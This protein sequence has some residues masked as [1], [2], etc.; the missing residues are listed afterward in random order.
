MKKKNTSLITGIAVLGLAGV[1]YYLYTRKKKTGAQAATINPFQTY[2]GLTIAPN[3]PVV[4]KF[5]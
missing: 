1:A 2:G 4:G 3:Q 5:M